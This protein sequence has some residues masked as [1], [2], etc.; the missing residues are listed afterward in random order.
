[1]FL[2]SELETA[3]ELRSNFRLDSNL[4]KLKCLYTQQKWEVA[5][6]VLKSGNT[7]PRIDKFYFWELA[8]HIIKEVLY[9]QQNDLCYI[10]E[11]PGVAHSAQEWLGKAFLVLQDPDGNQA[12]FT[13]EECARA[14]HR[15]R[16]KLFKAENI[17][18]SCSCI[19]ASLQAAGMW[20]TLSA[21]G[22][23]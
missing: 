3:V 22:T 4:E 14:D 19:R 12:L 7:S 15:C 6:F 1:M 16:G 23:L 8:L 10:L 11:I 21:T 2:N 18:K 20:H 5:G 13:F 9:H 17:S